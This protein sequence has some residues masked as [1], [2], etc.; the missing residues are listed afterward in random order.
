MNNKVVK[1]NCVQKKENCHTACQEHLRHIVVK[2]LLI[3][4]NPCERRPNPILIAVIELCYVLWSSL[5]RNVNFMY[6]SAKTASFTYLRKPKMYI[7]Y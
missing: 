6:V 2:I 3:K 5:F 7:K 4:N 1:P